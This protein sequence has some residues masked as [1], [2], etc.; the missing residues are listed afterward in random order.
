MLSSSEFGGASPPLSQ[1]TNI[2]REPRIAPCRLFQERFI[3]Y[4]ALS[5]EVAHDSQLAVVELQRGKIA[6]RPEIFAPPVVGGG[7]ARLVPLVKHLNA[8]LHGY[9][10]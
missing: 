10:D 7:G 9:D 8:V 6:F 3:V 4:N 1:P 2:S 5:A